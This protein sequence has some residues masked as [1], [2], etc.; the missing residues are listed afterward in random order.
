[1]GLLD[2]AMEMAEEGE[3]MAIALMRAEY[4]CG[5]DRM[6]EG[7]RIYCQV[8]GE[9]GEYMVEVGEKEGEWEASAGQIAMGR[10]DELCERDDEWAAMVI[11]DMGGWAMEGLSGDKDVVAMSNIVRGYRGS[12]ESDAGSGVA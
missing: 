7:V 4:Y 11:E 8:A 3:R 9:G 1:M 10:L 12:R 5:S 2:R 6:E